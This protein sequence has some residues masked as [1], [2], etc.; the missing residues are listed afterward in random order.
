MQLQLPTVTVHDITSP[1]VL[2]IL[3]YMIVTIVF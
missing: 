1:Y 2:C 3:M